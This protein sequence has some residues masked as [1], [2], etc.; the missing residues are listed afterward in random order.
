MTHIFV[1]GSRP[2]VALAIMAAI[3]GANV[4]PGSAVTAGEATDFKGS[5]ELPDI[6]RFTELPR[7]MY[8]EPEISIPPSTPYLRDEVLR[9]LERMLVS[10]PDNEIRLEA[11]QSLERIHV[12][13]LADISHVAEAFRKQLGESRNLHVRQACASALAAIGHAES[14]HD[15]AQLCLPEF[16]ALCLKIEPNFVSWGA[17]ALRST[18]LQRVEAPNDFSTVQI[19]L[20]CEGLVQLNETE[21]NAVFDSMLNNVLEDYA[22]RHSAAQ[23]LGAL[24]QQQAAAT[25]ERYSSGGVADRLL[26]C[27]LLG[28]CVSGAGVTL[29]GQLCDDESNAV[30]A[31]AWNT[32]LERDP[33][34]LIE[35]LGVGTRHRESNVRF[36]AIRTIRLF[37]T[38]DGCQMLHVLAG[39]VHI[40][41]RNSAR[42]VLT[43]FA[44][45]RVDLRDTIFKNAGGVLSDPNVSWQQLEQSLVLLGQLGNRQWQKECLALLEHDRPEVFVTAAWLLHLMPQHDIAEQVGQMTIRR[46]E[47]LETTDVLGPQAAALP[48]QLTFLFQ[49]AGFTELKTLQKLCEKQFSKNEGEREKR[50]AGLWALGKING[51]NA[52]PTITGKLV[53]RIFDDDPFNPEF[54]I[55]RRMSVLA[56]VWMNARSTV[57]DMHRIRQMYGAEDMLGETARWAL[58]QLGAE[59]PPALESI[60]RAVENF[61]ISPL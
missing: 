16:Q 1:P 54:E 31:C 39:D 24:D 19:R 47:L 55:V 52:D 6:V 11:I 38:E 22:N 46:H 8:L 50:A 18:W 51:G 20:A 61:P 32:M 36:A 34:R 44:D 29:L 3:A 13:G 5:F 10:G 9:L 25:A 30:A 4:I 48:L 14:A 7:R 2:S 49:H 53:E 60:R 56:L 41:V 59:Q 15:V 12:A 33:A 57:P 17:D 21:A 40:G 45:T 42:Q 26:A 35:K 27:A 37:P 23:A 28:H 58:P 43:M